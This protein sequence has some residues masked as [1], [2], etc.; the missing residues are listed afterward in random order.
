[1][2]KFIMNKNAQST[3]EHEVHNLDAG[4][5]HLPM[6]INCIELGFH[7]NCQSAVAYAKAIHP[8]KVIDGC[9]F[10]APQCHTR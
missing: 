4:C 1:M 9:A 8:S 2:P 5:K 3:G 6:L 7:T 10:C